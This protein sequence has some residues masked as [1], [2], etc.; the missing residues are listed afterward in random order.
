MNSGHNKK[1]NRLGTYAHTG[2]YLSRQQRPER[3]WLRFFLVGA[4]TVGGLVAHRVLDAHTGQSV[5]HPGQKFQD[6]MVLNRAGLLPVAPPT[7]DNEPTRTAIF[8]PDALL[9]PDPVAEVM[10]P[11]E[12]EVAHQ[13]APSVELPMGLGTDMGDA[14]SDEP[15]MAVATTTLQED[16]VRAG[17]TMTGMLQRYEISYAAALKMYKA[18]KPH[19]D[20][21]R[22]M[23]AGN[24]VV[25]RRDRHQMFRAFYYAIT[26][27]RTLVITTE[28]QKRFKAQVEQRNLQLATL[29]ALPRIDLE[30]PALSD[31]AAASMSPGLA[32]LYGK[33]NIVDGELG[34]SDKIPKIA[35]A[36]K[37]IVSTLVQGEI[38]EPTVAAL[39]SAQTDVAQ[40]T[41][42][43][44]ATVK[45]VAIK[46]RKPVKHD[47]VRSR[48]PNAKQVV[49]EKVRRGDMFSAILARHGVSNLVAFEM[50]KVAKRQSSFDIAR[51]LRPGRELN[52]AFDI[53]HNLIGLTYEASTDKTLYIEKK[54]GRGLVAELE[55]KAYQVKLKS[56][57]GIINGSLLVAARKAGLSQNLAMR[58]AGLFEWDVDFARD[59]RAGDRFTVVYEELQMDGRKIRNGNILAAK[60][61]NQGSA[62]EAIRYKDPRGVVGYYKP[63]GSSVEKM[64]IKAPVDFTRIS[65]RFSLA[66]K[67]PVYGFTRAHKGVD[68]AAPKGT[69]IRASGSGRILYRGH[70]GSFG[71]LVIVKHNSTYTTAYAHMSGFK[72]GLKVGSHIKQGQVIGYVGATGA[73]TGPHLHYEVRV[74]GRQVN[75][76]KVKLPMGKSVPRRYLVDFKRHSQKMTA[77]LRRAPSVVA[78]LDN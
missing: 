40:V 13:S 17:D 71:N 25:I 29:E 26:K 47:K 45:Q 51:R 52:M 28:D 46:K 55:Q 50:A 60:F 72:R 7:L 70:K 22:K 66:R 2:G 64:F 57:T 36:P 48:F 58:L 53:K 61:I 67:H 4:L 65:S 32:A 19:Y 68:Y 18:A 77:L 56:V 23:R 5:T 59:I 24:P 62:Y 1:L 10:T 20:L 78:A 43:G 16:Q 14:N 42:T 6:A 35:P 3:R 21:A 15:V 74:R 33:S 39:K 34:L 41:P 73:A 69:P 38:S 63:T 49:T 76:L 11:Q 54:P 37:A 9:E 44:A 75:P 27:N 12:L 30:K 31:Q 8:T